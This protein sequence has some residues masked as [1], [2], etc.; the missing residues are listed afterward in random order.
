VRR[1]RE[2]ARI[3]FEREFEGHFGPDHLRR[4]RRLAPVY[5]AGAA[6]R[7]L[8]F[9]LRLGCGPA[10]EGT[11]RLEQWRSIRRLL[12]AGVR[13]G[14][15]YRYAMHR[16]SPT[17]REYSV[18]DLEQVAIQR[19]LHPEPV[20]Q[21]IDHKARLASIA[22]AAG[23]PIPRPVAEVT[24]QS[25]AED[26][27]AALPERDLFVKFANLGWGI[28]ALAFRWHE[29]KWI[30][31]TGRRLDRDELARMLVGRSA[32][33]PLVV[34]ERIF[35]GGSSR[36]LTPGG[37]STLRIV[38]LRATR[39][40]DPAVLGAILRIPAR[41]DAITDNFACG[42]LAAPVEDPEGTL[43]RACTKRN[44]LDRLEVHPATGRRIAG[45]RLAEFP[46]ALRLA[47]AAHR[48]FPKAV[49]VGWDIAITDEGPTLIE[50]NIAWCAEFMQQVTG[51][52]L[53]ATAFGEAYGRM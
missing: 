25:R 6:I 45:T 5:R 20:R 50:G 26:I 19:F 23:L 4:A 31:A 34:Q 11:G 29:G 2:L 12:A 39:D 10:R 32:D 49:S 3:A 40:A 41:H 21:P 42:G 30:D 37:L 24:T 46:A 48:L 15:Y 33:G 51:V 22:G 47:I 53:L 38:T 28:G 1:F 7:G 16:V 36:D 17:L 43:G 27:A 9:A 8:G 35:N 13:P 14:D 44:V 52:P 18:S